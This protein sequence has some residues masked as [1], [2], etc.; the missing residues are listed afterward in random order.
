MAALRRADLAIGVERG[1]AGLGDLGDV[2]EIDRRIGRAGL[3]ERRADLVARDILVA[4][5]A[6]HRDPHR[7]IGILDIAD[8]E[9]GAAH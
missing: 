1:A 8:V 4:G 5:D 3:G 7:A 9:P 6:A 2:V